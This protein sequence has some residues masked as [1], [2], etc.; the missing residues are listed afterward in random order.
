[1][2]RFSSAQHHLY[3]IVEAVLIMSS[4]AAVHAVPEATQGGSPFRGRVETLAPSAETRS[5]LYGPKRV[6]QSPADCAV[7]PPN[8]T[9]GFS[10]LTG[11]GSPSSDCLDNLWEAPKQELTQELLFS[12]LYAC[13]PII[14]TMLKSR[15]RHWTPEQARE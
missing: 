4:E 15:V 6:A 11:L 2:T 13:Y 12:A 5:R 9:D 8:R 10:W 1:M 3:A 7:A 14:P